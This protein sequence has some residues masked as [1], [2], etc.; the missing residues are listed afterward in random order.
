M[1]GFDTAAVL[2]AVAAVCGYFNHKVLR[3]PATSG[4]LAVA[5]LSSLSIV[6]ANLLVP[7]LHL[8]DL[9]ATFVGD[10]DFDEA[11]MHS[12]P[13]ASSSRPRSSACSCGPFSPDWVSGCRSSCA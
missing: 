6:G 11:L 12:R 3:L 5:L 10:I 9:V 8:H 2:I 7:S 1:N 13:S 4:T